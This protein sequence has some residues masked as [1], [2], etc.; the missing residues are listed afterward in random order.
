MRL[1]CFVGGTFSVGADAPQ[2]LFLDWWKL[3]N[4]AAPAAGIFIASWLADTMMTTGRQPPTSNHRIASKGA[5][6]RA[7]HNNSGERRP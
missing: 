1:R 7:F 2:V 5:Q 4:Y 6:F 3:R